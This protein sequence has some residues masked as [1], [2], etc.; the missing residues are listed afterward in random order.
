MSTLVCSL[1][2]VKREGE[3]KLDNVARWGD[4]RL[5]YFHQKFESSNGVLDFFLQGREPNFLE[6]G[7]RR[8]FKNQ[9]CY[10]VSHLKGATHQH[11]N[12]SGGKVGFE[13]ATDGIQLC[14]CQLG[15]CYC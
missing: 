4:S 12:A 13:L 11:A 6:A 3:V 1:F 9:D 2:A 15:H 8:T 5:D 14:L 10:P 7:Y